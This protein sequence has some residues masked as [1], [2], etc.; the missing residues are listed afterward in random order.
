VKIKINKRNKEQLNEAQAIHEL[1]PAAAVPLI[2]GVLKKA[3][4]GVLKSIGSFIGLGGS[5]QPE[6]IAQSIIDKSQTDP[7]AI[8]SSDLAEIEALLRSIEAQLSA[9]K[10]IQTKD[11]QPSP[12]ERDAPAPDKKTDDLEAG[13]AG[14][15]VKNPKL[16]RIV[17]A[18]SPLATGGDI[19]QSSRNLSSMAKKAFASKAF[20]GKKI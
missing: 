6:K 14:T 13:P 3:L 10:D 7:I 12:A 4:P 1:A 5:K 18:Q 19:K 8:E 2:G 11:D 9:M 15:K 16:A 17:G 20:K